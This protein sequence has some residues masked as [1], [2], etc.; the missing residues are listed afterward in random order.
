MAATL[1]PAGFRL[2]RDLMAVNGFLG[3]LVGLPQLMNEY[4]YN[5]ALYGTPSLVEPWGW[6]LFGHHLAVNA[7]VIGSRMVVTPVFF[8]AEPNSFGDALTSGVV[9][10]D[11]I[12]LARQL[13]AALPDDLRQ[14]AQVY[15]RMVDPAMPPGRL[16]PGDERTLAGCFQ[17]NRVIP[18]EGIR[19]VDMPS[20][21]REDARRLIADFLSYLP[22]GPLTARLRE[23]DA[24]A[25][26]TWFCW[27][28]G[29]EDN[30]PFYCRVQSPVLLAELDHHRGVFLSN[31]DPAP[32]HIHTIVRTPNGGDYGRA[33]VEQ[34][35]SS[36]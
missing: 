25:E 19:L 9:F 15:A 2:A 5:I 21:A 8:G 24:V 31:T 11:R 23:I 27:I 6:H 36:R 29:W 17:D 30:E 14:R 35:L 34:H 13:M 33:L 3:D 28:G 32:F 20:T 18:Y 4:S 26:D 22:A 16:H 7:L 1:S 10:G 12:E